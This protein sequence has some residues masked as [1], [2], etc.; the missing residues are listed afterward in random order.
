MGILSELEPKE[1]FRQFEKICE[2]PHGSYNIQKI[3]DYLFQWAKERGLWCKQD[4]EGNVLVKCPATKG[5]ENEEPYI[6][7]GHMDMVAV[8][9]PD[10]PIDLEKDGLSLCVEGDEV[11]AKGTSL[12]GD[13]GIAIAYALAIMDSDSIPHPALEVI[14][15]TNE[16]VGME[17]AMAVNLDEFKGNR[18]INIDHEE[19]GILLTGCAGGLRV[20]S[21]FPLDYIEKHG[22]VYEI[23]IK[24]L[25]GGHSGC[26][27]HHKRANANKLMGELLVKIEKETKA[28]ICEL[29]GGLKDNAIPLQAKAVVVVSD[30]KADALTKL[31]TTCENEYRNRFNGI[32]KTVDIV[33][34]K[35][36]DDVTKKVWDAK[37][38]MV[39][40][41]FIEQEPDGVWEM[42]K[43][44]PGLVETSLNMGVIQ[45]EGSEFVAHQSLRS[46]VQAEK[47]KLTAHVCKITEELGGT[48]EASGD[49]PAWEYR[50]DSP[51]REH[52]VKIYEEMF[53]S[54]P[55]IEMIHAGLECGILSLKIPNLDCVS[56]GPEIKDIHTTKERMSISSVKRVWEYL[57]KVLET[58]MN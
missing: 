26:E 27:I 8:K 22:S 12:G 43:H 6:I 15:T 24:G 50:E 45:T 3:S 5:Y 33:I 47:E 21:R 41:S 46:S 36:E 31:I 48:T 13:D 14:F 28:G 58:K 32:E 42:S 40:F 1:V 23:E 30:D 38:S 20:E 7:Q 16:E 2:I 55:R 37:S 52:M 9:E 29:N 57:L 35:I 54:K 53:G 4:E 49:Y 51:L 11:F 39:V 17:G 25:L 10:C 34:N 56:V 18:M 44:I 19:E